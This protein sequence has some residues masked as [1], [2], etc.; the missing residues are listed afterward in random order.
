MNFLHTKHE[1]FPFNKN[2]VI[3]RIFI[4]TETCSNGRPTIRLVMSLHGGEGSNVK[5]DLSGKL[6]A[7]LTTI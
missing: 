1:C 2:A 3:Q 5:S 6:T 4:T 7:I